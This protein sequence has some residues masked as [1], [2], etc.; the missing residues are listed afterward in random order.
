MISEWWLIG[1]DLVGNGHCLIL[2][3]Y[4]SI[5]L[6]G[7][8]KT[9]KTSTR[10]AGCWG[11]QLNLG[12]L[13]YEVGVLTTRS[14]RSVTL[15]AKLMKSNCCIFRRPFLCIED[16]S[17]EFLPLM[18]QRSSSRYKRNAII[19]GAVQWD[20]SIIWPWTH[21]NGTDKTQCCGGNIRL[22]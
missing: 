8:R 16:D 20:Y 14:Q 6:E 17:E 10:I 7:L 22:H 11:Q 18:S 2:R 1:N 9:M 15:I 13:E 5:R 3:H 4:P 12:P 21:A 19:F